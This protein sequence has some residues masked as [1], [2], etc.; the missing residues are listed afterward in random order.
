MGIWVTGTL[1]QIFKRSFYTQTKFS[2][3]YSE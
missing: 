3:R 1:N 2:K